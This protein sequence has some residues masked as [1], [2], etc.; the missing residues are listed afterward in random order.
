MSISPS[1]RRRRLPIEQGLAADRTTSAPA[2]AA[3]PASQFRSTATARFHNPE[4]D[5]HRR[6]IVRFRPSLFQHHAKT[7]DAPGEDAIWMVATPRQPA[8]SAA[9]KVTLVGVISPI[10]SCDSA[11]DAAKNILY[12]ESEHV[13]NAR[14]RRRR[15]PRLPARALW[16]PTLINTIA[17][18]APTCQHRRN[19][20][21]TL[22]C[23]DSTETQPRRRARRAIDLLACTTITRDG[24]ICLGRRQSGRHLAAA[25]RSTISAREPAS[26]GRLVAGTNITI[27]E[28]AQQFETDATT[29]S[30]IMGGITMVASSD[31]KRSDKSA[32]PS[33]L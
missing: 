2:R 33:G 5:H 26:A 14:A 23:D 17:P 28:Q 7:G 18:A 8:P 1:K 27:A 10:L 30:K 9:V 25:T 11:L 6:G 4:R 12:V 24:G 31:W 29:R 20:V 3:L 32:R 16:T 22:R 21:H 13:N 15:H 19:A